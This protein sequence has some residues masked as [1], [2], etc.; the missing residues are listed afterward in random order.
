[1]PEVLEIPEIQVIPFKR[2]VKSN[3]QL[4]KKRFHLLVSDKLQ[5]TPEKNILPPEE[6]ELPFDKWIMP[7]QPKGY[8][9][10]GTYEWF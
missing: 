5:Y 10:C 8:L 9:R 2:L 7:P 3:A 6:P 4:R 1:M